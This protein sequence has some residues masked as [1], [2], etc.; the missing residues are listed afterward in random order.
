MVSDRR[1]STGAVAGPQAKNPPLL[2]VDGHK[3][4]AGG[5]AHNFNNLLMGI[6]GYVELMLLK[7]DPAHRRELLTIKDRIFSG[8][9]RI[10]AFLQYARGRVLAPAEAR[11]DGTGDRR[12]RVRPNDSSACVQLSVAPMGRG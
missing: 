9:N 1:V 4:L 6:N 8:S 2:G 11:N 10:Q 3:T 5:I 7:A 12:L